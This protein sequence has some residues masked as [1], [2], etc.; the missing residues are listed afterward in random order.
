MGKIFGGGGSSKA[1]ALAK[2]NA[3][4]QQRRSLAQLAKSQ[5]EADQAGSNPGGG[6]KRGNRMLTYLNGTSLSGDGQGT[7]G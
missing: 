6:K 2:K 3:E 1:T 4:E 5:A 7:L